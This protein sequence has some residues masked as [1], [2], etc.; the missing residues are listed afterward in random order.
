MHEAEWT[1]AYDY[2][3][4][5]HHSSNTAYIEHLVSS[6]STHSLQ[7]DEGDQGVNCNQK[8]LLAFVRRSNIQS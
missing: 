7:Q 8:Q 6:P 1:I 3:E 5:H 4:T 2:E